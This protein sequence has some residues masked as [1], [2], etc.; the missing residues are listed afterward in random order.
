MGRPRDEGYE[1]FLRSTSD[2]HVQLICFEN[3]FAG[4]YDMHVSLIFERPR[5]RAFRLCRG[6]CYNSV[7]GMERMRALG[8]TW[9]AEVSSQ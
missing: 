6:P 9:G 3:P 7:P 5:G 4:L 8:A 1:R 2:M